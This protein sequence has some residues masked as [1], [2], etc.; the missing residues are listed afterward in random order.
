[1][2]RQETEWNCWFCWSNQMVPGFGLT[3]GTE[4]TPEGY[5][6][7]QA[8]GGN[9]TAI[10]ERAAQLTPEI[11]GAPLSEEIEMD[12]GVK[13]KAYYNGIL[14]EVPAAGVY[15]VAEATVAHLFRPGSG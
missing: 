3:D 1:M 8:T 4:I 12:G 11:I 13:L 2:L 15:A 5:A 10:D 9:M 6:F 7:Q 14:I